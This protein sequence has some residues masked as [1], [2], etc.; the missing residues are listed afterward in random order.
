MDCISLSHSHHYSPFKALEKKV[1]GGV[2]LNHLSWAALGGVPTGLMAL[3]GND[4][5]GHFIRSNLRS[6]GVSTDF[7]KSEIN[8][9][10]FC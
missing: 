6:L 5:L 4:E 1:I 3:Q 2:T 7:I 10:H 8:A 9:E